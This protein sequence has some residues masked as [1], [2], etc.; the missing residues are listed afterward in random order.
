[1]QNRNALRHLLC[2]ACAS[3][4]FFTTS[5]A[6]TVLTTQAEVDAA[7]NI[8]L[9]TGDVVFHGKIK[10]IERIIIG[11]PIKD[12]EF[13]NLTIQSDDVGI[14]LTNMPHREN[15]YFNNSDI[16]IHAANFKINAPTQI[17]GG[18]VRIGAWNSVHLSRL[19]N[20]QNLELGGDPE[21]ILENY[22]GVAQV[23]SNNNAI[24]KN[25]TGKIL[26]RSLSL[27]SMN[28]NNAYGDFFILNSIGGFPTP[29][30]DSIWL[31]TGTHHG[32]NVNFAE[33]WPS[34]IA[35]KFSQIYWDNHLN[36]RS[37]NGAYHTS[38]DLHPFV[39]Y[40]QES[41]GLFVFKTNLIKNNQDKKVGGYNPNTNTYDGT[42][43][44]LLTI[45]KESFGEHF[46]AIVDASNDDPNAV[47]PEHSMALLV[48]DF[49]NTPNAT[50]TTF[51][52]ENFHHAIDILV[53]VHT[54]RHL[55]TKRKFMITD[56]VP[57]EYKD[58]TDLPKTGR[59]W[60]VVLLPDE[61][62][63]PK[64]ELPPSD[65]DSTSPSPTD[66][67]PTQP[68]DTPNENTPDSSSN[69]T[70]PAPVN[71]SPTYPLSIGGQIHRDFGLS[72]AL[73]HTLAQDNL[74][75]RWGGL[76]TD[77][78]QGIW[79]K[80]THGELDFKT[81]DNTLKYT[82]LQ[83]G[84]QG[85]GKSHKN[86]TSYDALN[87]NYTE[88]E[89]HFHEAHAKEKLTGHRLSYSRTHVYDSGHYLDMV[90]KVG[91]VSRSL[92]YR[93]PLSETLNDAANTR[94]TYYG[95]SAEWGREKTYVNGTYIVPQI[96]LSYGH[97]GGASYHSENN[98]DGYIN[99][100]NSLVLRAGLILGQKK[101]ASNLYAKAFVNHEYSGNTSGN[102][103]D[104]TDTLSIQQKEPRTWY[105]LGLG[106]TYQKDILNS[107][108]FNLSTDLGK[109]RKQSYQVSVG[110]T[111]K[112]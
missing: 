68:A 99:G 24:L 112:F 105:T 22:N 10:P 45:Q 33:L 31:P 108:Y 71:P 13:N 67:T 18:H 86:Y 110:I 42:Y 78:K 40:C 98:I 26:L 23:Y 74:F 55:F 64:P 85:R 8:P 93:S 97:L 82:A 3:T 79:A 66:T 52:N 63:T 104:G 54:S 57:E 103:Y 81:L 43:N 35:P 15:P 72:S 37:L 58:Y 17:T 21:V 95:L 30:Q 56:T 27:S 19:S 83:I 28:L 2:A 109:D 25:I 62:A 84:Y 9:R 111:H 12:P 87:Y 20:L 4:L 101:Q 1:M 70:T 90:G 61:N 102:F 41:H 7:I 11:L 80:V 48:Q 29:G 100:T 44:N 69:N 94:S 59:N 50:F 5:H 89:N 53:N 46:I 107:A 92:D 73:Y 91:R 6:Q 77:K 96:Q 49:S 47:L 38:H 106:Y 76:P 36:I 51:P 39:A 60:Y 75:K 34:S 14:D 65:T 16:V 88:G 32:I